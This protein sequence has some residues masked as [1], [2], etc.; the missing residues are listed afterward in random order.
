MKERRR[1][2]VKGKKILLN[3]AVMT[4]AVVTELL[5]LKPQADL[6]VGTVYRVAPVDDV[7][8]TG[9]SFLRQNLCRSSG[10]VPQIYIIRNY[11]AHEG[12]KLQSVTRLQLCTAINFK[13]SEKPKWVL[14]LLQ[15][16]LFWAFKRILNKNWKL[17]LREKNNWISP[18]D[19]DAEIPSNRPRLRV[20][21][22]SLAEHHSACFYYITPL[23]DLPG[24]HAWE[25]Q[26][27]FT[28]QTWEL[29]FIAQ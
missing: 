6:S 16:K 3:P 20:G 17:G 2:E 21:G 27:F 7:P 11:Q 24:T 29:H 25:L 5:W 4:F 23:P 15:P 13:P 10:S 18:A 8:E 1:R 19:L 9:K 26:S 14:W 28:L 22:V 12:H